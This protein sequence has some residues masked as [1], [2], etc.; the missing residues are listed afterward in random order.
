M[1]IY[2]QIAQGGAPI[3]RD[4]PQIAGMIQNKNRFEQLQAQADEDRQYVRGRNEAADLKAFKREELEQSLAKIEW[5]MTSESPRAAL[6]SDPQA[7]ENFG[8]QGIDL[9][10]IDDRQAVSLLEKARAGISSQLG[11]GPPRDEGPGS[12]VQVDEGG[13]P[14]YRP[15]REAV[16]KQAFR[17]QDRGAQGSWS[18]A[19]EVTIDGKPTMIQTHSITGENRPAQVGPKGLGPKP[20]KDTDSTGDDSL[21]YRQAERYFAGEIDPITGNMQI[22]ATDAPKVQALARRATELREG[23]MSIAAAVDQAAN[24]KPWVRKAAPPPAKE[25][26]APKAKAPIAEGTRAK[27]T[28]PDG[29][30]EVIELRGGKWVPVSQ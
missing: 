29:R 17:D 1:S 9:N 2:D 22:L 4:L 27:K 21:I 13:K 23:G 7:V 10:S 30:V 19:Y 12:L 28:H 25:R 18:Q 24:E 3:G 20:D 15:A 14:V 6:L 8:K 11:K 26:P 5:A 16:G